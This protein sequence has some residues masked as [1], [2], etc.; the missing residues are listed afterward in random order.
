[1][2]H[3]K[4]IEIRTRQDIGYHIDNLHPLDREECVGSAGINKSLT[5]EQVVEL[6]YKME[7]KPN[8]IIKAGPNAKWYLTRFQKDVIEYEIEKQK[9]RDTSRCF[10]YII[11]WDK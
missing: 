10:M 5:F 3:V 6:A 9:W 2:N 11:E 4:K 8:I 7:P 1:M